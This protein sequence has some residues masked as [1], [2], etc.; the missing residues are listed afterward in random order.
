MCGAS[1]ARAHAR[2]GD[3][4]ALAAYVGGSEGSDRALTEFAQSYAE[5]NERTSRRRKPP[6]A[7]VGSGRSGR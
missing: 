2:S 1:P 7:P 4:V 5:Q 3:P 6:A